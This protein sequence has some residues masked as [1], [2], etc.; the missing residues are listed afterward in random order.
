[1]PIFTHQNKVLQRGDP[2]IYIIMKVLNK[3]MKNLGG[4]FI[5]LNEI[6][7]ANS[8]LEI[9]PN[10]EKDPRNMYIGMYTKILLTKLLEQGDI[11][12]SDFDSFLKATR[13]F[14]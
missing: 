12:Q 11:F 14:Y 2:G 7:A 3:F 9:N 5:E 4:N 8:V 10:T 6:S 1:M 13:C